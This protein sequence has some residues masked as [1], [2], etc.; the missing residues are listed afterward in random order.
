MI[1]R[2]RDKYDELSA[3]FKQTA[4]VEE[5]NDTLC[6]GLNSFSTSLTLLADINDLEVQRLHEKV[7]VVSAVIVSLQIIQIP[8]VGGPRIGQLW[9]R[10]EKCQR[11]DEA[12]VADAWQRG[13]SSPSA[14]PNQAKDPTK[15]GK[16][17]LFDTLNTFSQFT[18]QFFQIENTE[19]VA[20]ESKTSEELSRNILTF[21]QRKIDDL[22]QIMLDFILIQ[23]KQ[24][25]KSMEILSATY[26]D[27]VAIDVTKDVDAFKN[28]FLPQSNGVSSLQQQMRSQSMN[29]LT[30]ITP[31]PKNTKTSNQLNGASSLESLR[32]IASQSNGKQSPNSS[33]DMVRVVSQSDMTSSTDSSDDDD[34]D[35]ADETDSQLVSDS[36]REV[37]QIRRRLNQ[38]TT[39]DDDEDD[40]RPQYNKPIG[41]TSKATFKQEMTRKTPVPLVRM[42]KLAQQQNTKSWIKS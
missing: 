39:D 40:D 37:V 6:G 10:F 23:L 35:D 24:H 2:L 41:R 29:A 20:I 13:D 7:I 4:D 25:V 36:E 34:D 8:R 14:R 30:S 31:V 22:K 21:E 12:F 42:S 33:A 19:V 1:C 32:H 18:A 16:S 9:N 27:I 11:I 5:C 26:Q 28:K 38:M 15:N 17:I 3:L